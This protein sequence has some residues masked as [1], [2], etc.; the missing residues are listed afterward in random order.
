[1]SLNSVALTPDLMAYVERFG[2]REHPILKKL[3]EGNQT[4][5]N[6]GYQINPEVA[7]L[8]GFLVTL[9]GIRRILEIGTFTGY[10]TLTMALS[11]PD[12][13]SLMTLDKDPNTTA[14]AEGYWKEAGVGN[15]IV[16]KLGN[17]HDTLEQLVRIESRF[18]MAFIDANK[19][20]YDA[21]YEQCLTLLNPGGLIA[22]D[23][24]LWKGGV[25]HADAKNKQT[26]ALQS[27]NKKLHGD[28]RVDMVLLPFGDGLTL[29]R[30]RG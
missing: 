21:Y 11:L 27:L 9:M 15:K 28:N 20:Q 4:L 3:R 7:H 12:S 26:Q 13:G 6:R 2:F 8:L 17:A 14:I 25:A 16:L 1:M 22:I 30:K 5:E 10:S 29:L 23:N 18:D 19:R 24:T